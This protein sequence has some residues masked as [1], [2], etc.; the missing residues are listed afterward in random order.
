MIF[1]V[2]NVPLFQVPLLIN[3]L[4]V[5]VPLKT[6]VPE[7]TVLLIVPKSSVCLAT[8]PPLMVVVP[9]I[10]STSIKTVPPLVPVLALN[11]GIPPPIVCKVPLLVKTG[12]VLGFHSCVASCSWAVIQLG[13]LADKPFLSLL[14]NPFI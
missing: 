11:C 4:L 1:G 5:K 2:P 6:G 10:G 7:R 3:L 13:I 9:V 8:R 14:L 12:G